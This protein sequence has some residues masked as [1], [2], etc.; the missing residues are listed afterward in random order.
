MMVRALSAMAVATSALSFP[1]E[2]PPRGAG[3]RKEPSSEPST[4]VPLSGPQ[5][6]PSPAP[7]AA[8]LAPLR[9]VNLNTGR[10]ATIRLYA[11][12]GEPSDDERLRFSDVATELPRRVPDVQLPER[13]GLDGRLVR[14]VVRAAYLMRSEVVWILSAERFSNKPNKHAL[15][16][17]IDFRLQGVRA[18][19]LAAF[20]RKSPRVGVGIYTHPR[21]QYVHLDVREESFHWIDGSPPGVTWR[22]KGIPDWT[23]RARDAAWEPEMDLP[24]A[25]P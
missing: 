13:M 6:P 7:W 1:L 5:E 23:T 24:I 11:D 16:Q 4:D 25:A 8:P 17:A 15:A 14:L 9:V 19:A 12:D 3:A 20:L 21:T 22:E 18:A 2:E 10:E